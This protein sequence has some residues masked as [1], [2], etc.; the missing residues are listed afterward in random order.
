MNCLIAQCRGIVA[1]T[2]APCTVVQRKDNISKLLRDDNVKKIILVGDSGV[3]KTWTARQVSN[4]AIKDGLFEI[5][6]WVFLSRENDVPTLCKSIAHQLSLHPISEEWEAEDGKEGEAKKENHEDLQMMIAEALVGKRFLLIL[7]DEGDK[8]DEEQII[9]LFNLHLFNLHDQSSYKVIITKAK[10]NTAYATSGTEGVI[11]VEPL[12]VEESLSLWRERV[13]RSIYEDLAIE[14]LAKTFIEK[15]KY[16]PSAIILMAKA[17]SY[18]VQHDSGTRILERYLKEASASDKESYN[19]TQLVRSGYDL[20]PRNVLIDCC[21]RGSHYFRDRGSIH[22]NELIAYWVMEGYFGHVDCIEKAYEK[23]HSVFME[24][25]DFQ[26][27]KKLEGGFVIMDSAIID[28]DDSDRYGFGG[29]A[30]LGLADLSEDV[31]WEGFGR[32]TQKDGMIKSLC[33]GKKDQKLSTL[34][35]NGNRCGEIKDNFFGSK[36]ELQVLALFN[37]TLKSLTQLL[38]DMHELRVL[39]LRGCH[40]LEKINE[41]F[42]LQRLTVLEIS[43]ASSLQEIPDDF[44]DHMLQL[45]SLHISEL[46]VNHLPSSLEKLKELRWLILRD[47]SCFKTLISLNS[48][49]KLLVCDVSGAKSLTTFRDKAFKD[50]PKLQ[51]LDLS[52]T[53]IKSLP[54]LIKLGDLT[55]F[56]L[57]GCKSLDRLPRTESLT[58]LQTLDLSGARNFKEFHEQSLG[59]SGGLKILDLS[60]TPLEKLPSKINPRHLFLK[61]CSQLKKLPCLEALK[62]LEV[63]DLSGSKSLVEIE[64]QF[65]GR[66]RSLQILNLSETSIKTLPSLANQNN[67]RQLL[68]SGCIALKVIE[69]KSFEHMS[70]L[71]HLDLSET[72][73]EYLPSLLNLSNLSVLSLKNCTNL[74]AIPLLES[75]TN[76]EEL[77]LCGISTLTKNGAGFLEHRSHLRILDLSET[78]LEE[79]PSMSNLKKLRQISLRGCQ[80]LQKVL[81]LEELTRLEVLDLSRTAV[82]HLPPL[83]NFS[84]LKQL[85]LGGCSKL[86]G[87]LDVEMH[88]LLGPTAKELPYGISKLTHLECLDLPNMKTIEEAESRNTK[89]LPEEDWGIS[90]FLDKTHRDNGKPPISVNGIQFLQ[91]LKKNPSLLTR[92]HFCVHPS[93]KGQNK[94]GDTYSYGNDLIFRDTHFQTVEFGRFKDQRVLEINGFDHFPKGAEDILCSVDCV[95]FINN[96]FNKWL[97]DIGVSTLKAIK[98]CWIERCAEMEG[99]FHAGKE[100]DIAKLG[101]T[102]EILGVSN[103]INLYSVHSGNLLWQG[104][105][106]LKSL[107]LDC[108]PKLSTVFSSSQLPKNLI[109]LQV[110]FCNKLES[111]FEQTSPEPKLPKLET[112]CLWELPEL[113]SIGCTLPSLQTLKVWECPKLQNSEINVSLVESLQTLWISNVVDLKSVYSGSQQPESLRNLVTLVL[114]SCPML[115]NVLSSPQ[116]PQSLKTLKIKSCNKLKTVF[117]HDT[118]SDYVLQKLETLDLQE[119]PKLEKIGGKFPSVEKHIIMG[120]PKCK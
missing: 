109:V 36:K 97:S 22:Y 67:I 47:C 75:L 35:L 95:F 31:D 26:V 46:K 10:N 39:V 37:P 49:S 43:N 99:V 113:K 81:N 54:K 53:S 56:S 72:S 2:M 50:I 14:A 120:C 108:C 45:Q 25:V 21:R 102:L 18:F 41:K 5:A 86:E 115:E 61:H 88:D 1:S 90:S 83:H 91:V 19:I 6:V 106:N 63:L 73:L 71:Q 3:G 32:I 48:F 24:L 89:S 7:D 93:T 79:L 116:P 11:L 30:S 87:F 59:N 16:L 68:L 82:T 74:I 62:D 96:T 58:T 100:E 57:S 4:H 78:Q 28:L 13:G 80:G 42:E 76:L 20:L 9:S 33:T 103:A 29:T 52:R 23:G 60:E 112:L 51:T 44:F 70:F 117:E 69:D 92:F 17:F 40:F 55:H 101:E 34:F 8:M 15:T 118:S 64:D 84:N 107:Y 110:K 66:L 77:N 12:S 114:Q 94:N 85:L 65:F 27:L 105:K 98:G 119:L 38:S 104:F 111:V